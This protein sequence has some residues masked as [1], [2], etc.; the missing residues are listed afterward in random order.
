M[1]FGVT[2]PYWGVTAGLVL[3]TD[4]FASKLSS[5]SPPRHD[6][7]LCVLSRTVLYLA[8]WVG[9]AVLGVKARYWTSQYLGFVGA[10]ELLGTSA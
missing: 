7:V 5:K 9:G 8:Y 1:V 6:A 3:G 4:Q 2:S 10:S